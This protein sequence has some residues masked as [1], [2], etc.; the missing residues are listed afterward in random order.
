MPQVML[1]VLTLD[2]IFKRCPPFLEFEGAACGI[3]RTG[4]AVTRVSASLPTEIDRRTAGSGA[5]PIT[6]R[7]KPYKIEKIIAAF[8]RISGLWT[9]RD[10]HQEFLCLMWVLPIRAIRLRIE[11]VRPLPCWLWLRGRH[12][13]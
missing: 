11:G 10:I 3:S 8:H 5:V 13:S 4:V 12:R 9:C 2:L 6:T 1:P 7:G